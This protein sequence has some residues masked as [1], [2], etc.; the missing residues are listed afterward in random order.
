MFKV[1]E[2]GTLLEFDTPIALLS[3]PSSHLTSLVEQSGSIEAKH[4][5]ALANQKSLE[6][7][8]NHCY[9]NHALDID[10]NHH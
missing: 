8:L 1:L 3:N 2:N 7:S 4:L 10:T 5:R 6:K 9:T